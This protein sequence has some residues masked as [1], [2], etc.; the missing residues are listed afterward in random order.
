[1]GSLITI[2]IS[3]F[4]PIKMNLCLS[5]PLEIHYIFCRIFSAIREQEFNDCHTRKFAKEVCC[6][7]L[8]I[9]IVFTFPCGPTRLKEL[10]SGYISSSNNLTLEVVYKLTHKFK[11]VVFVFSTLTIQPAMF[12]PLLLLVK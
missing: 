1:M 7:F 2:Q 3:V 10:I 5:A 6:K 8:S 11:T 9:K 4:K 12:L